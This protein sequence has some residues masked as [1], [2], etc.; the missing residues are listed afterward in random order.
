M[1][2]KKEEQNKKET[3]GAA[4]P[5]EP[6]AEQAH[7]ANNKHE[8]DR[9]HKELQEKLAAAVKEKDELF[10][11]L[12]RLSADYANFQKRSAKQ[13]ADT[14]CFEKE[15]IIKSLL[16]ALDNFEHTLK[17][18]I[19]TDENTKAIVSG[20]RIIYD[21]MLDILK[22]CDVEQITAIGQKFDPFLHQAISQI[23]Q[24]DKEDN[25]VIEES[26][27]GYKIGAKVIRPSRVIV[28]KRAKPGEENQQTPQSEQPDNQQEET[29]DV[30]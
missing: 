11:R 20:I 6:A 13:T 28:N 15:K 19:G 25:I 23:N 8:K 18:T 4:H 12:Q 30:E 10:A 14:V 29:T 22:A 21:H 26:Q 27:R 2:E 9:H 7:S 17:I 3:A 1:T 16:P 24:S 5:A